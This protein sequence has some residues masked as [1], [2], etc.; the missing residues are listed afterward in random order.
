MRRVSP[1]KRTAPRY[2]TLR[3]AWR[4]LAATMPLVPCAARADATVPGGDTHEHRPPPPPEPVHPP[5]G[6]APPAPE[7]PK[8]PKHPPAPR[9]GGKIV[10]TRPGSV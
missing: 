10:A 3:V 4:I 5:L 9:L 2:P 8:P 1:A 7:P 6:G